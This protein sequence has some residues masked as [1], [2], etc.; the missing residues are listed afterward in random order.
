VTGDWESGKRG[1]YS[2]CDD[3]EED[4]MIGVGEESNRV[5]PEGKVGLLPLFGAAGFGTPLFLLAPV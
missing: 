5:E 3:E 4:A 1:T 2:N